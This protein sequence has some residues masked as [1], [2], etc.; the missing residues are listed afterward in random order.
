M[1]FEL[2]AALAA[3][4]LTMSA[5]ATRLVTDNYN[6]RKN[7]ERVEAAAAE[8]FIEKPKELEERLAKALAESQAGLNEH[9]K[10]VKSVN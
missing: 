6:E 5:I 3:G 8:V 9:A 10:T 1:D 4:V 7:Q 2:I